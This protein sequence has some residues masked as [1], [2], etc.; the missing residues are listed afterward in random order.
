[1]RKRL[2]RLCGMNSTTN[3]TVETYRSVSIIASVG[4]AAGTFQIPL[5]NCFGC[6]TTDEARRAIDRA[7]ERNPRLVFAK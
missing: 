7:I 1:M 6:K 3:R 4:F 2:R 5:I